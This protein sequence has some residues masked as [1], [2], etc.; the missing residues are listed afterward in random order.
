MVSSAVSVMAWALSVWSSGELKVSGPRANIDRAADA[1]VEQPIGQRGQIGRALDVELEAAAEA[2]AA[3]TA[4]GAVN[5]A[6]PLS[7]VTTISPP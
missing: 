2:G 1:A 7:A 5:V 3:G 4:Q 6:L